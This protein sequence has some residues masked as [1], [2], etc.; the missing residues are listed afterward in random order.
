M[1]LQ[2]GQFVNVV[3]SLDLETGEGQILY[4]NPTSR[5]IELETSGHPEVELVVQDGQGQELLRVHPV[6]RRATHSV[7]GE[8]RQ[9]L[10]Q[11]DLPRSPGMK[12]VALFY[13]GVE[14]ARFEGGG[15]PPAVEAVTTFG[16]APGDKP[17][18][19]RVT[20]DV[21]ERAGVSYKVEVKPDGAGAWSTIAVG[22]PTPEVVV[23]RNQFPGAIRARLRITRSTGFND[24]VVTEKEIDLAKG[25]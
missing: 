15:A 13:K 24:E 4:V 2:Q 18:R 23:D 20:A 25:E 9:S 19:R 5:S 7:E 3:A 1:K 14:R 10:I 17:N 8:T 22:R 6:V 11:Q 21:A 12:S 16:L